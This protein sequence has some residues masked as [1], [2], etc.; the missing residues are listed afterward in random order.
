MKHELILILD[1]IRSLYNVGAI[2][3]LA[4]GLGVSKLYLC[5]ITPTPPRKEIHKTALG[6]ETR[7]PW[8]HVKDGRGLMSD[9]KSE[10]YTVAALE[11]TPEAIPIHHYRPTFPL[12]L[13]VGHEREGVG[14]MALDCADVHLKIPMSGSVKSLNVAT[15]GAIAVWQL[16]PSQASVPQECTRALVI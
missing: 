2:F 5:G 13:I 16:R 6:A 9:L 4:D 8:E 14:K 11:I 7:I 3:R 1:S 12:A 10:G 15:A